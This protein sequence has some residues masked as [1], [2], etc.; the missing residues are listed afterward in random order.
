MCARACSFQTTQWTTMSACSNSL[1]VSRWLLSLRHYMMMVMWLPN[2]ITQWTT[3]VAFLISP[4]VSRRWLSYIWCVLLTVI[5]IFSA[6]IKKKLL[7]Q[8]RAALHWK[9]LEKRS[10]G[11]LH[12]IFILHWKFKRTP[13]IKVCE[14]Y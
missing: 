10:S 3:M 5:L 13:S 7:S 11:L 12:L 14:D 8:R 1:V 2:M 4:V 6:K 9:F